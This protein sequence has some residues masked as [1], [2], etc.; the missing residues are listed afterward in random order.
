MVIRDPLSCGNYSVFQRLDARLP[1]P[2]T[3]SRYLRAAIPARDLLRQMGSSTIASPVEAPHALTSE[4]LLHR[5]VQVIHA[6]IAL[7][8]ARSVSPA[9]VWR[10]HIILTLTR[11]NTYVQTYSDYHKLP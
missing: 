5:F 10:Y 9:S 3:N 8:T 2:T 4:S 1:F 6:T 11:L 7:R